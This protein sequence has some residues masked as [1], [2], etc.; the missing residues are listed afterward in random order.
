MANKNNKTKII[1][2][3]LLSLLITFIIF[4]IVNQLRYNAIMNK[5]G[6][7]GL[8]PCYYNDYSFLTNILYL[9]AYYV[10]FNFASP[11]SLFLY[12][13]VNCIIFV[14]INKKFKKTNND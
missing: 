11:I 8:Y 4:S 10:G 2:L 12:I 1:G 14:Q 3:C 7:E 5:M 9:F 13:I 6:E